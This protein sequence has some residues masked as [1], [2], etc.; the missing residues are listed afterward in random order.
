M[1]I[2]MGI[3]LLPPQITLL[4]QA[5]GVDLR[6]KVS[7]AD[8]INRLHAQFVR[9]ID[10]DVGRRRPRVNAPGGDRDAHVVPLREDGLILADLVDDSTTSSS[11]VK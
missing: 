9:K 5:L 4:L 1:T 2:M 7:R 10:A 8:V 6:Y 11:G 3:Y